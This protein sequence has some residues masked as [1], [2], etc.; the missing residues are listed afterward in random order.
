MALA[1][2]AHNPAE[3][4]VFACEGSPAQLY[5]LLYLAHPATTGR[6]PTHDRPPVVWLRGHGR[7]YLARWENRAGTWWAVLHDLAL[8]PGPRPIQVTE[9][10]HEASDVERIVGED[11][12]QVPRTTGG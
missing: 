10:W 12:R 9:T 5:A 6:M 8:I 2:H 11:Y 1:P 3:S 4:R 7:R